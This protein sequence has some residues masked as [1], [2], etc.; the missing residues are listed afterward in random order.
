MLQGSSASRPGSTSSKIT[1]SWFYFWKLNCIPG[2]RDCSLLS[3]KSFSFNLQNLSNDNTRLKN[4]EFV[5]RS[6]HLNETSQNRAARRGRGSAPCCL[7]SSKEQRKQAEGVRAVPA[8][9]EDG[10]RLRTALSGRPQRLPV[11]PSLLLQQQQQSLG[12]GFY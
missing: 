4:W 2:L 3:I 10:N 12:L 11:W 6:T 1:R 5:S 9:A 7:P 8:C